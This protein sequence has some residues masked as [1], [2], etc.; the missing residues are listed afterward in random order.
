[1]KKIILAS[2]LAI[3]ATA[4]AASFN[5][6]I[7]FQG[8]AMAQGYVKV[9]SV[10]GG[11]SGWACNLSAYPSSVLFTPST[12]TTLAQATPSTKDFTV[13][14][15]YGSDLDAPINLCLVAA[16]AMPIFTNIK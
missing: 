2:I 5:A 13:T 16:K 8:A 10:S 1:M 15:P 4:Q 12:T 11:Q 3:S 14:A 6:D 7:S 9:M